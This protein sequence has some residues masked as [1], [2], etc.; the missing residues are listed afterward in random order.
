VSA[1]ASADPAVIHRDVL[2]RTAALEKAKGPEAYAALRDLW[3]TWDRA[4]PTQIEAAIDAYAESREATPPLRVYAELL[5]AYARRRRGDFDGAIAA[6]KK[7]GF[8]GSWLSVGPFDNENKE[9]FSHVF[10]PEEE[11]SEP[12]V[13]TR[14]YD[15]KERP[16]H[17]RLPPEAQSYGWF[18]FGD[19]V[20]PRENVC[21]Y[22]TTFVRSK[23]GTHAPRPVTLWMGSSGAFKLYWN[24]E[25]VLEDAGYRAIDIDRFATT[26]TL[27]PGTNRITVKACGDADAPRFA[28]RIGDAKGAPDLG[29]DV[30]A[31]AEAS[32]ST[33]ATSAKP[34][35]AAIAKPAAKPAA[36][37]G[38]PKAKGDALGPM[39]LFERRTSGPKPRPA[40]LEAFARYLALTGGDSK[41][42]H[43]ARDLAA[44][45]AEA[46]PSVQRLL[47][48]GALAEDRNQRR[49]WVEK[50]RALVGPR[51]KDVDVLLAEAQLAREG[52]NWRDAV[53]IYEKVLAIDPDDVSAVLGRVELYVTAGLKRTAITTLEDALARQPSSVALLRAYA[54]ELR[55][56]GRET[57]ASEVE[58]RYAA[59]RFDD[60]GFLNEQVELAV[61]RRD[62][63]GAERWLERL[64][65]SEPDGAWAR[66]VA[67]RTY[68]ALG[69]ADRA[70]AAYERALA[71][72]PED[73]G[74]LRSLS[75]LLAANGDREGQLR[76]LRQILA[77]SPQ[78]K[79]VREYVEHI[80]PP[81]ERADEAYAW[82]PE[83]FL[84]M[85]SAPSTGYPRRTLRNLVVTTVHPNGLASH[86]HQVVYQPLTDEAAAAGREYAFEYHGDREQV[87]L[88]AAR[89]YRADGKVDEAIETGEAAANDPS[90]AMYTSSRTFYVHFPRLNAGDVVELRWRV[91]DTAQRN[92]IADYFGE[93]EY[94]QSDE[95]LASSEYVLITPKSRK[96]YVGVSKL[97]GLVHETK[98]DGDRRI[99]RV[100][101]ENVAPLAPEPAMPPWSEVLAHVHVS[102]FASWDE[103][104]AFY[105]G[106]VRE[107]FDVDDEVRKVV[108]DITKG[109][110]DDRAKVRAIFKYAT[111][112][113]Y[114][115]LEFGLE[116]IKPR[117]CAQTLARGWGDCKD[118]ATLIVTMLREV[119]IPATIVLVRTGMRGGIEPSPASLAP[120]DHA[121]A[122][123]PSLDLYLDGTAENTGTTELPAM[124]RGAFALQINEGHP[125]LVHL[126]MAPA[127]ASEARRKIDVQLAADGSAQVGVDAEVSGVF[128]VDW[129]QRYWAEGTRRERATRDLA[130]DFG[131]IELAGKVDLAEIEDVEQP[132]HFKARG[133]AASFARKEGDTLS[134]AA[135]PALRLSAQ[136][137][138]LSTRKLEVVLQALTKR[139]EE[140][141]VHVPA[142]MKVVA[143]PVPQQVDSPFGTFSI[144]VE[145]TA[146]KVVVKSRLALKK[147]RIAPA[148]YAGFRDFCEAVD[149]AFG[150]RVVVGKG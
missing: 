118:K 43:L 93:I 103:L 84:P 39:Q 142:G 128:A 135:G 144:A 40:D 16:V 6:V 48:A 132:V 14:T 141:T 80:E 12:L 134:V 24:G 25:E 108:K 113:R 129:R 26:V 109:L 30:V 85:R 78:A 72:A 63:S 55:S 20:R 98:E 69:E 101:A 46:E 91:E 66:G 92:E 127:D 146:G 75:D 100:A 97:P 71:M 95:P 88:R 28:L 110:T 139:D 74:T 38:P 34:M 21:A 104:G 147:S 1:G 106:L 60:S 3:R 133:R 61:A 137:A 7:L 124:D 94:L 65:R 32:A 86:F 23:A 4:N 87:Q 82:A 114:V 96:F 5:G 19:L 89:V 27:R 130:S 11:L 143:S 15:G 107:Q 77:L 149:R 125:K 116:G 56:V 90:I 44:R 42:E 52:T 126:P 49:G 22:A 41:S 117:R 17:W 121:I 122:Y 145:Q 140:W 18:D 2:E 123:V 112:A 10:A 45:A 115:A 54:G 51:A 33:A 37:A 136:Y 57:E 59:L 119:G 120:F 79:D 111:R 68:R 62:K 70:R 53:P 73:V 13:T 138:S 29:V 50:A 81:K 9:G 102:T 47:L 8:V 58:A 67:A 150:Q 99:E 31:D 148:D 35:A 131:P 36:K 105:W 83:R 76:L 64:L